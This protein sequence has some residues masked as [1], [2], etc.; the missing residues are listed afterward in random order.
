MYD[1]LT[2]YLNNLFNYGFIGFVLRCGRCRAK[3]IS[4]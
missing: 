2:K 3:R 1:K 4:P